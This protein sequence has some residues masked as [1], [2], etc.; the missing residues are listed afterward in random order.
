[1]PV[2]YRYDSALNA[3]VSTVTG[4]LD[5]REILTHLRKLLGDED[6][7]SGMIEIVDFSLAVDFAVKASG[8]AVIASQ[9]AEL[10]AKKDYQGTTFF[11]PN[12][13]SFGMAR[14][15]QAMMENQGLHVEIY[16]DWDRM[17]AVV[18]ERLRKKKS[19]E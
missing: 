19:R 4:V 2:E 18:T 17:A 14:M 10:N 12:D 8:A 5:E 1:M 7:P 16:R 3:V 6:V 11:A 9:V 13:L 15:F